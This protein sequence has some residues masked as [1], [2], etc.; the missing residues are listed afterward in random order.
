MDLPWSCKRFTRPHRPG[1]LSGRPGQRRP[2]TTAI[3]RQGLSLWP[4]S[5]FMGRTGRFGKP[6]PP[7][8]ASPG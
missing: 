7:K 6:N 3:E 2:P 5:L 4:G 8:G 1:G